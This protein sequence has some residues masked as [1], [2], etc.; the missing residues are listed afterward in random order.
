MN[1]LM[2]GRLVAGNGRQ[3][4]FQ[5]WVSLDGPLPSCFIEPAVGWLTLVRRTVKD[6][7]AEISCCDGRGTAE[8]KKVIGSVMSSS[9]EEDMA[10]VR[11]HMR[12]LSSLKVVSFL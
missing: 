8:G 1:P 3:G 7:A 2:N 5:S 11:K 12:R 10:A 9:D 4:Q 6:S